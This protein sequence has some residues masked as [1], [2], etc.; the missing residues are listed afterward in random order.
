MK[1]SIILF[2]F[3]FLCFRQNSVAQSTNDAAKLLNQY[4][5]TQE[6][7]IGKSYITPSADIKL[8]IVADKEQLYAK[9]GN[10]PEFE[11]YNNS[12][13][14]FLWKKLTIKFTF[15]SDQEG[16]IPGLPADGRPQFLNFNKK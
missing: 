11:I 10:N 14:E 9:P 5:T 15:Q 4:L 1:R 16:L 12:S 7:R 2:F 8:V 13:L 6:G 3:T